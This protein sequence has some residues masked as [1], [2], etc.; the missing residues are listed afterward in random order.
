MTLLM[1]SVV[2]AAGAVCWRLHKGT[3]E[4][5]LVHRDERSDVSLPKG[6]V[7]PGE[8]P[9]QTAVREIREETGLKV[10]L[11][12]P[13]GTT[14]YTL[15]GGREKRVF[16]WSAEVDDETLAADVAAL[17]AGG[18]SRRDAVDQVAA[19]RGV[20]RRRVYAAATR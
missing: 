9:P 15:P 11:G 8:T 14:E 13:L 2:L 4:V 5:L 6:K 20:A 12:P 3:I 18:R 7:D 19:S 10:T 16:Y 17:V 1:P